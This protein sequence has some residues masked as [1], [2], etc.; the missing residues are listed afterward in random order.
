LTGP[1]PACTESLPSDELDERDELDE[2]EERDEREE[3]RGE[4]DR[5]TAQHLIA[6][7]CRR[8]DEW[9]GRWG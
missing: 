9:C 2:L 7:G 8:P 4:G 5:V 3:L 6:P 1:P